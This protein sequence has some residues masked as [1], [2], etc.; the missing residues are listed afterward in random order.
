MA[1]E[2]P[3]GRP[4]VRRVITSHA[5]AAVGMGLPW[6]VLLL[7]VEQST[8]SQLVLGLAGAARLAPYVAFSWLSGRLADRRER[9]LIVRISLWARLVALVAAGAAL[10]AGRRSCLRERPRRR[11]EGPRADPGGAGA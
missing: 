1:A 6:P 2:P 10:A 7:A 8:T 9:A 5:F 11:G 3:S 4:E